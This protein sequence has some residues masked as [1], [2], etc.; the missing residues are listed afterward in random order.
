MNPALADELGFNSA[1]QG[2][3]IVRVK[4]GTIANRLQFQPG[5]IIAKVNGRSVAS[6][7][8]LKALLTGTVKSWA[9]T[10][11]RGGETFTITVGD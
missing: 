2:V 5:D 6:V 8:D 7:A 3:T 1:E 9:I 10:I 11:R 4:R